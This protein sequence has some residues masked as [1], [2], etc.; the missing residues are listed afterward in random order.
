MIV[1]IAPELLETLQADFQKKFNS[2]EKIR[3]LNKAISKPDVNYVE[4]NE[5]ALEVGNILA[6]VYDNNL[7][8]EILPNG[9]MYKNIAEKIIDPTMKQN[10]DLISLYAQTVQT[11]LNKEAGLGI[12]GIQA[13]L[14]QSRIDGVIKKV[15]EKDV[16]NESV[17]LLKESVINFSQSIVDD[18]IRENVDFHYKSGLQPKIIRKEAGNCCEW[19][20]A[21]VGKYSYPDVPKDVYRR[22]RY[23]RCT[24]EYYPGDGKR[25][26]VHTKKWIDPEKEGKIEVRKRIA[27]VKHSSSINI[28]K[29]VQSGEINLE[30]NKDH[31]NKHVRGNN[32]FDQY[33]ESRIKKGLGLQGILTIDYEEAQS[34]IYEF[35]GRGIVQS[36]NAGNPRKQEDI[37][38]GKVI[39]YYV[40]RDKEFITTKGRIYYGKNGSHI[41][42]IKGDNFD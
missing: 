24:V 21:V 4:A 35:Y 1:D 20:R 32:Q 36:T 25:Q 22:H 14:N 5:F 26:D 12:K 37:N 15:S 7:S 33:Y 13:H 19:C 10:Y 40:Y 39:G 31:Y 34:L 16:F 29:K 9:K 30:H 27:L 28:V 17:S 38:F 23:C 8:S 6:E 41:V 2:S 3:R 18:T 42:P 11:S